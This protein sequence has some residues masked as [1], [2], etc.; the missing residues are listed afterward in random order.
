MTTIV[1]RGLVADHIDK[2]DL[3]AISSL[4]GLDRLEHAKRR[5][6]AL[7]EDDVCTSSNKSCRDTVRTRSIRIGSRAYHCIQEL[8]VRIRRPC[9]IGKSCRLAVPTRR[10]TR[11]DNAQLVEATRLR[12]QEP[13]QVRTFMRTGRVISNKANHSRTRVVDNGHRDPKLHSN[14]GARSVETA[15]VGD[16][17]ICPIVGQLPQNRANI[18]ITESISNLDL[19]TKRRSSSNGTINT[20][21]I[22]PEIITLLRR[23]NSNL[24]N[25]PALTRTSRCRNCFHRFLGGFG[26]TVTATA[27]GDQ[28]EHEQP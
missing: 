10:L 22:P 4:V 7:A 9:T 24:E 16:D 17:Q 23:S 12:R 8:H 5:T 26:F 13:G 1:D 11:N 15:G 3:A 14:L 18:V 2:Q 25:R 19:N 21:L 28:S 20:L 6:V 27:C